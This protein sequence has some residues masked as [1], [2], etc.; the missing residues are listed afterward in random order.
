MSSIDNGHVE[1]NSYISIDYK[2]VQIGFAIR[3]SLNGNTKEVIIKTFLGLEEVV[4]EPDRI[5]L[6]LQNC[7]FF[8]L[9][10]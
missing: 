3:N 5:F 7:T 6:I 8:K 4:I 9:H 10:E 1:N 2:I